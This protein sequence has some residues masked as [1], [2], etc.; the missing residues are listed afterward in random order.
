MNAEKLKSKLKYF[1]ALVG[2]CIVLVFV[3]YNFFLRTIKV[4]VMK[5]IVFT[6]TGEN[7]NATVSA[8][9][10]S[11]DLNKRTQSFLDTVTYEITPNENLSNGDTIHVVASY[12]ET[13]S[14]QY[15]FEAKKLE[16]D[17][18][19]EGLN[20]RYESFSDIDV[21]YLENIYEQAQKYVDNHVKEIYEMDGNE[22]DVDLLSSTS[23]YKA[24]LQSNSSQ[25]SD[26]ILELFEL[27]Y[28][29]EVTI[30]YTVTIPNINDGKE[31]ATSDIFGEKAYLT[32]DEL[33]NMNFEGYV[34][35]LY[36]SQFN[37]TKIEEPPVSDT[38]LETVD[39][40]INQFVEDNLDLI[41]PN[42]DIKNSNVMAKKFLK[43]DTDCKVVEVFEIT[44]QEDQIYYSITVSNI[45][46]NNGI[47]LNDIKVEILDSVVEDINDFIKEKY[48]HYTMINI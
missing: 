23:I 27:V 29:T 37:I 43:S 33:N 28:D 42:V 39:N 44:D 21:D 12:D 1:S 26:R 4:D 14:S 10:G 7:G 40:R 9:N 15:H 3:T 11:D 25:T 41:L 32:E 38:Y 5:D 31:V 24:F 34:Q 20:N 18:T 48:E 17:F 13:I 2:M 22:G 19:V 36:G 16:A 30:Y 47:S 35:R 6:Y 8:I 46:E 45:E